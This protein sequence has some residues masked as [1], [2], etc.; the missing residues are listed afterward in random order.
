[1]GERGRGGC[2]PMPSSS[3]PGSRP[4]SRRARRC[5]TSSAEPRRRSKAVDGGGVPRRPGMQRI[6][7]SPFEIAVRLRREVLQQ[8]GLRVTVGVASTKSIAKM[9]SRR[10]ARRSA[11]GSGRPRAGFPATA[12]RGEAVGSW[13]GHGREAPR[14][15]NH[16]RGP[17]CRAARGDPDLFWDGPRVGISTTSPTTATHGECAG[18]RRRSIGSQ[19]ALGRATSS[20]D[21]LDL[22]VVALVDRV[23]RR[24]RASGRVGRTVT[25]RLRFP[26]SRARPAH[27]PFPGR[28]PRHRRCWTRRGGCWRPR[29]R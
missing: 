18:R 9:A 15:W 27:S 28:P 4:T 1:M 11:G 26:T 14:P 29:C 24:M 17:A 6:S 12:R 3:S 8:V 20:H 5:S 16:D 2:V 19:S 13:P 21:A 23:T 22:V 10:E 25:L 7:G